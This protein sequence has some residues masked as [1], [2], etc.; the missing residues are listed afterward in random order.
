MKTQIQKSL[1]IKILP[2]LRRKKVAID[3]IG[4]DKFIKIKKVSDKN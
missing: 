4:N 2:I 3:L 1:F